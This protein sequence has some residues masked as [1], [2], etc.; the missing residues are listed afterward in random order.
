S[1]FTLA[2]EPPGKTRR[3]DLVGEMHPIR[4]K[5][6]QGGHGAEKQKG[7]LRLDSGKAARLGG[8]AGP[9]VVPGKA[10]ASILLQ[11]VSGLG[12]GPAMPPGDKRLPPATTALLRRWIEQGAEWPETATAVSRA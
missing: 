1:R 10:E 11:R 8:D 7:G 5:N 3:V 9:A 4:A 12:D 2:D 6:C